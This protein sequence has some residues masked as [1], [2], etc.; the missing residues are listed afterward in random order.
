MLNCR[1]LSNKILFNL[2]QV[3][4]EVLS[5]AN[6]DSIKNLFTGNEHKKYTKIFFKLIKGSIYELYVN[7]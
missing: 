7:K 5:L 4:N 3:V 6:T 2:I 1:S